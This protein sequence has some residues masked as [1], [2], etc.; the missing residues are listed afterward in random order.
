MAIRIV[1]YTADR[2]NEW[3][4]F[5]ERSKNGTFLFLRAYMDYHQDRFH[6]HSLLYYNEKGRLLAVMP[7]NELLQE[8]RCPDAGSLGREINCTADDG[9]RQCAVLVSHQGLTYGGLVLS[10]EART[11]DVMAMFEATIYY[12]RNMGF[13]EWRYKQMPTIYHRCP[14][15]ED[16]Y[17]LWRNNAI[18]STCLISTTIPL[19]DCSLYPE[20]ERR[21][22]R[23]VKK[24]Q[25]SGYIIKETKAIELFWPIMENNLHDR[26]GVRPVHTLDEMRLLMERFPQNIRCYLAECD[27]MVHAGAIAYLCGKEVVH[28]QYGHAT[29]Q[30]KTDGAL[31]LL[32]HTLMEQ[33]RSQG[34]RFFD[35]GNSNEDGGNYLNENLIAQKEGFGGRGIAYK[36][37]SIKIQ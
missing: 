15:E 4:A 16:E 19:N 8:S 6:D 11:V 12:L 35:F 28:I 32:Y 34:I 3:D 27:G 2:Q 24:A 26:Y 22:R 7:A 31:D 30:G 20:M 25:Q 18:L 29:P 9:Q 21:R 13:A 10:L 23:G 1:R 36:T 5:V 33:Y 37:Y 14:A 17:A